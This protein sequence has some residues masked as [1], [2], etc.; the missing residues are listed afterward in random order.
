M[1]RI[2][3]LRI[4]A[5]SQVESRGQPKVVILWSDTL[6]DLLVADKGEEIFNTWSKKK[7]KKKRRR[8]KQK[9]SFLAGWFFRDYKLLL[10]VARITNT[11][12]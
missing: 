3:P 1:P 5:A 7:P 6:M 4:I 11:I 9:K 8:K 12:Y 10:L 2:D